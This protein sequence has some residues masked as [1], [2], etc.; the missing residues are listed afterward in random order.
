MPHNVRVKD[1]TLGRGHPLFLIG[2]PCVVEDEEGTLA[3]ARAVAQECRS[4][5][6]PY[7]FKSSF[8]KANRTSLRSPRGPGLNLGLDILRRVKDELELPVLVDVHAPDQIEGAAAVADILQ[9]PAFLC[10]Q[11]D[12]V[13][14]VARAGLPVNVKKGQFLTPWDMAHVI[15][16]VEDTGNRAI[17]LTERGACFGYNN[18]VVDFRSFPVLAGTGYP[19]IFDV[20]HSVQLPGGRGDATGGQREFIRPLA[21]AAVAAGVD[22]L[23]MEIH[24][25]PENAP[26]DGDCMLPLDWLPGLLD[27]ALAIRRALG[28]A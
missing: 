16:K 25:E 15:E 4:R 2:G 24:P 20:T 18:L 7:V 26:C 9:I 8:D 1:H 23:F 5:G 12:F 27:E 13:Q 3:I 14:A 11:T 21:R 22:G 17:L 19:V 6:I 28:M 10:R